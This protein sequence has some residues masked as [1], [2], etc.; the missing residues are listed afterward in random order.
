M[1]VMFE[2]FQEMLHILQN[3][4]HKLSNFKDSHLESAVFI[5]GTRNLPRMIFEGSRNQDISYTKVLACFCCYMKIN[6]NQANKGYKLC[7]PNH[8]ML[9]S[10]VF[11]C[12]L[13][14]EILGKINQ[15]TMCSI[16]IYTIHFIS[17]RKAEI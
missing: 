8:D 9:H 7:V 5:V 15:A 14:N 12:K 4:W 11:H 1:W 17:N 2:Y 13:T 6:H 16:F 10:G 3:E